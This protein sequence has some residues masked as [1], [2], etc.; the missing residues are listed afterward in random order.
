[1]GRLRIVVISLVMGEQEP[2]NRGGRFSIVYFLVSLK[3]YASAHSC[4]SSHMCHEEPAH[5][6]VISEL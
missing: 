5:E 3:Y 2:A 4:H 1:M 6:R